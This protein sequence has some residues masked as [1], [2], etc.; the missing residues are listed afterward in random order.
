MPVSE[1]DAF[2]LQNFVW[3]TNSVYDFPINEELTWDDVVA[4]LEVV[5]EARGDIFNAYASFSP[6]STPQ[7]ALVRRVTDDLYLLVTDQFGVELRGQLEPGLERVQVP[8]WTTCILSRRPS[9]WRLEVHADY[10]RSVEV[11]ATVAFASHLTFTLPGERQL[12]LSLDDLNSLAD[13]LG[14]SIV[15][16]RVTT[17]QEPTGAR[18]VTIEKSPLV[19]DVRESSLY[20]DISD[21][22]DDADEDRFEVPYQGE[23]YPLVISRHGGFWFQSHAP[24]GLID[25]VLGTAEGIVGI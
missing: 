5:R 22:I 13:A 18:K 20:G 6:S 23:S 14:A 10:V 1:L 8:R 16:R 15:R 3:G 11:A 12:L 21:D 24:R 9:S 7:I 17:Q 19:G 2:I 25:A 4:R